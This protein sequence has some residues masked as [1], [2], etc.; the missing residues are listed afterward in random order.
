MVYCTWN[1]KVDPLVWSLVSCPATPIPTSSRYE[2]PKGRSGDSVGD[3]QRRVMKISTA[4]RISNRTLNTLKPLI[5]FR[6][7]IGK[8]WSLTHLRFLWLLLETLICVPILDFLF[9]NYSVFFSA[10][11]GG[12]LR[13][14]WECFANALGIPGFRLRVLETQSVY[15]FQL[16]LIQFTN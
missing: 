13:K 8:L 3:M 1:N 2:Q 14:P 10:T 6:E 7:P 12:L 11:L 9:A 4:E 15:Y 5:S 16:Y